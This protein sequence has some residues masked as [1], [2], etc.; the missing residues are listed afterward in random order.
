MQKIAT[1]NMPRIFYYNPTCEMA[2]AN[3]HHSY[4]PPDRLKQF[5]MDLG[6]I[7]LFLANREDAVL[8]HNHPD[9]E[10]LDFWSKLGKALPQFVSPTQVRNHP[11]REEWVPTP[12]GSSKPAQH[13]FKSLGLRL[14][15]VS[16][17]LKDWE[18]AHQHFFSRATSVVFERVWLNGAIPDFCKL[19]NYPVLVRTKEELIKLIEAFQHRVV[20]KSLWSSSGRGL[21]MIKQPEHAIP[22]ITWANGRI[23][24]EGAVVVEPLMEK[25]ADFSFQFHLSPNNT[26]RFLGINYFSTDEEGKF[27]KEWIHQPDIFERIKQEK[28]LPD[29]WEEQCIADLLPAL[30]SMQWH[31]QYEGV[32]GMDAMI[33]RAGDDSMRVR[34]C[35]E[36]NFR[37]N[38]GLINMALKPFFGDKARGYWKIEQF[39]P[40]RWNEFYHEQRQKHPAAIENN[41][42]VSGFFPLVSPR[43][44]KQY[45][46][47]G[48]LE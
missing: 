44:G 4:Q 29:D 25:V 32:L 26:I 15:L 41:R 7:L 28:N 34:C 9:Q 20:I 19:P 10:F 31:T 24:R 2:I 39:E 16:K 46:A 18:P 30:Q 37:H 36:I 27:D 14:D 47:W 6:E 48:I 40:R 11:N 33:I 17:S 35:V 43:D 45:A 21:I 1:S 38:M 8:C 5:E 23:R 3:N 42:L 22:A 12:W 13:F